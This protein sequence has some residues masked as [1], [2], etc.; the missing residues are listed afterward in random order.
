MEISKQ[1][2]VALK[3]DG[4]VWTWG[5]NNSG[6]LGLG[7]RNQKVSPTKVPTLENI[8][9][10]A[11]GVNSTI[12]LKA[13]G[14]VW[15][16]GYN[17]SGQLGNQKTAIQKTPSQVITKDGINLENIVKIVG[18]ND[19]LYRT[20]AL[21]KFGNVWAWGISYGTTAQKIEGLEN[22]ID[23]S[24]KYVV[25]ADGKVIELANNKELA[26]ENIVRVEEGSGNALFLTKDGKG[27]GI[28]ENSNG[29]LGNGNIKDSKTPT[30]ILNED[31]SNE[32]TGIKQLS[33]GKQASMAILENGDTY[34]WGSNNNY[35]LATM[36]K[37]K[38]LYPKKNEIIGT[39]FDSSM[40]VD[41]AAII[42]TE[43]FIYTWGQGRYGVIGNKLFETQMTPTLVGKDDVKLSDNSL[44]VHVDE[45]YQ[46]N[47]SN[48]TFNVLKVVEDDSLMTYK[49]GNED[50][51]T[52]SN[53]GLITG[54]VPGYV[55][56]VVNKAG[57]NTSSI[58]QLTVLPK[59]INIEPQALTAGSH[60]TILKAD[61]TV[62]CYGTNENYELGNEELNTSDI[63]VQVQF[64]EGII[65]KQIAVA[66]T[67]NLALDT[68]GDVW[69]W[70]TDS[71]L[72]F[73]SATPTKIEELGKIKKIAANNKQ[74]IALNEDGYIYA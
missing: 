23:I 48:K 29:E 61:G 13:D 43:G 36:Q 11:V 20:V 44:T 71:I 40:G 63:P 7:D 38:Q 70:G 22:I 12:A 50:I 42:D 41:N 49:S 37:E 19:S 64:P 54:K 21:D 9:D 34:V 31:G 3:A 46:L 28:G 4:T 72:G 14:T 66:N 33:A 55:T 45:D 57:T 68:A 52:I 1:H 25:K 18:G 16:F 58:V 24:T 73:S 67:H 65:I 30:K 51:A 60:T 26:L 2:A 47:V 56:M 69:I 27:Y 6:Q 17:G 74:S 62:W 53:T 35:K 59:D 39:A 8:V 10:I 5:N 15:G 32:L